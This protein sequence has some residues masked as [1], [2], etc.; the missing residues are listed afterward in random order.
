MDVDRFGSTEETTVVREF[1]TVFKF[2]H[3]LG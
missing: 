3:S 1:H 2:R